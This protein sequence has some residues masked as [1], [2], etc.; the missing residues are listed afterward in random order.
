MTLFIC[1]TVSFS[2]LHNLCFFQNRSQHFPS[3]ILSIQSITK[4]LDAIQSLTLRCHFDLNVGKYSYSFRLCL[5]VLLRIT[6]EIV[7]NLFH[8]SASNLLSKEQL[9]YLLSFYTDQLPTLNR[10]RMVLSRV[11]PVTSISP[12]FVTEEPTF[13]VNFQLSS[14]Q[15]VD[16][17]KF[18]CDLWTRIF[19]LDS[20]TLRS[21][22][23]RRFIN[24]LYRLGRICQSTRLSQSSSL[25]FLL[26]I[27]ERFF[28]PFGS[29]T[30]SFRDHPAK[31]RSIS[32][33]T[34]H[35]PTILVS[36]LL[37]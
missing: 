34:R 23:L 16:L 19:F 3:L 21:T 5:A 30:W 9:V 7:W 20:G 26:I 1:N 6:I 24:D 27:Q 15:R 36:D 37:L 25:S 8:N 2:Y 13:H 10:Y 11:L 28:L 29:I 4:F 33:Q 32:S 17:L 35:S 18:V 31:V 22:F 12:G 14:Q